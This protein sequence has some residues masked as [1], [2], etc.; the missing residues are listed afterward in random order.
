MRHF[1]EGKILEQK[2]FSQQ[3]IDDG[4]GISFNILDQV[5]YITA[6]VIVGPEVE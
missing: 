3:G 5:M 1:L 6:A 4:D 2:L